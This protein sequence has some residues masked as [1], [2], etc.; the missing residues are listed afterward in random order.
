MNVIVGLIRA[1][2][3]VVSTISLSTN[4]K[5]ITGEFRSRLWSSRATLS[6]SP[7][8]P[9][10]ATLLVLSTLELPSLVSPPRPLAA[11]TP[12]S[13]VRKRFPRLVATRA[14]INTHVTLK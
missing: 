6:P 12:K 1:C 4:P 14:T 8:L 3:M 10:A 11:S 13:R 2:I 7:P 5:R 9:A